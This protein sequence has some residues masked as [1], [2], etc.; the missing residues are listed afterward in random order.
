M[1]TCSGVRERRLTRKV[2]Y[3]FGF[4]EMKMTLNARPKREKHFE[5]MPAEVYR[6][7]RIPS[8]EGFSKDNILVIA[9]KKDSFLNSI[10]H[11]EMLFTFGSHI[12]RLFN[13]TSCGSRRKRE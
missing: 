2:I 8:L 13:I 4:V 1:V 9:P 6:S 10:S 7:G 5:V 11:T 12:S 3:I